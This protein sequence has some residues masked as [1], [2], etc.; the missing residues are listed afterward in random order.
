MGVALSRILDPD[1]LD[2]CDKPRGR[3][4]IE[5]PEGWAG[6]EIEIILPVRVSCA[7]CDGGG[8]DGCA[9]RGGHR[10]PDDPSARRLAVR[11]PDALEGGVVLRILRPYDDD[12]VGIAQLLLEARTAEDASASVT[13]LALPSPEPPA[14]RRAAPPAMQLPSGAAWTLAAIAI[15]TVI[16]AAIAFG[17]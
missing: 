3:L 13:L 15:V 9:R 14:P 4:V 12:G 10:I 2:A 5:V 8:C 7:R 16:L 1:V 6:A 11:L 17:R